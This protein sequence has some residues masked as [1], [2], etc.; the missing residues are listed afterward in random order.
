MDS[1]RTNILARMQDASHMIQKSARLP[2]V[3]FW[4]TGI[5]YNK[6]LA[7]NLAAP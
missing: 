6:R 3:L 1:E 7:D 5:P 2:G 4:L